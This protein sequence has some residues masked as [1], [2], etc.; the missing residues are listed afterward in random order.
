VNIQEYISSGV[1]EAYVLGSLTEQ[2]CAEVEM[3]AEQY[4][5]VRDELTAIEDAMGAYAKLHSIEPSAGLKEKVMKQIDSEEKNEAKIRRLNLEDEEQ[6]DPRN[7]MVWSIAASVLLMLSLTINIY[8]SNRM[9]NAE[10]YVHE[11]IGKN[12]RKDSLMK[13]VMAKY[14]QSQ[15][16][17]AVLK[18]PMY[19]MVALKGQADTSAKAMVCWCP[20]SK[21]VYFEAD[22]MPALPKGMQYQLWAMVDGK[23]VNEGVITMSTGLHKMNN[24][25]GATE[26]AVTM[27]KEGGS[28]T[29]HGNMIVLG[30]VS[31]RNG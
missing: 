10:N 2:E 11:L 26:F 21:E 15:N 7:K 18:D 9:V 14:N 25:A 30:D 28:D 8:V 23:P 24:V 27:E 22:K 29:P 3:Y 31:K 4:S 6:R 17:L 16:D 13:I 1:L 5:E 19:K 20:D 12:S